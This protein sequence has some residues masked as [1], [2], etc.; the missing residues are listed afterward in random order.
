MNAAVLLSLREHLARQILTTGTESRNRCTRS[1]RIVKRNPRINEAD[2]S[3][4]GIENRIAPGLKVRNVIVGIVEP[5][6]LSAVPRLGGFRRVI[7]HIIAN[8]FR[9]LD[10]KLSLTNASKFVGKG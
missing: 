10:R 9:E 6:V 3:R 8:I 2:L 4:L 7:L 1:V 5:Q